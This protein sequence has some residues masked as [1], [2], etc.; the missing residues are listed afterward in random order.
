MEVIETN[1]SFKFT[2]D[3][4]VDLFKELQAGFKE[5]RNQSGE[6]NLDE[7]EVV[8]DNSEQAGNNQQVGSQKQFKEGDKIQVKNGIIQVLDF[9]IS[10]G[11]LVIG[12]GFKDYST[13]GADNWS[14]FNWFQTVRTNVPDDGKKNQ[15]IDGT[16]YYNERY[17]G[18]LP[19]N[20][21]STFFDNPGRPINDEHYTF[22][23]AELTLVDRRGGT[24]VPIL[25][26]TYGF[27][28][29]PPKWG[30]QTTLLPLRI[31]TPSSFH[32]SSTP[33]Q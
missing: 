5:P 27:V 9:R 3:D 18:M 4:A 30:G 32:K 26:L 33:K 29:A 28:T 24:A 19:S 7:N 14:G 10:S 20:W 12:L 2:G 17:S 1:E 31:T 21:T 11:G 23:Q 25:T 6:E 8:S 13:E 16:P 15:S 22:W